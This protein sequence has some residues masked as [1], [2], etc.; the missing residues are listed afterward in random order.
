MVMMI[1][2]SEHLDIEK[3]LKMALVHQIADVTE[4]E[5]A[6]VAIVFNG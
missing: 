1:G 5:V 2:N 3:C 6:Y 4:L